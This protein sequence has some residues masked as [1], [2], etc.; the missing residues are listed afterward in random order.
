MLTSENSLDVVLSDEEK[1]QVEELIKKMNFEVVELTKE[2]EVIDLKIEKNRLKK[3][4][5]YYQNK[6]NI[7]DKKIDELM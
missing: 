1:K 3:Y 5:D 6:I 2:Q 7:I 4:R